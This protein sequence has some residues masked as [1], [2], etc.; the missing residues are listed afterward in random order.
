[1]PRPP[2]GRH[3]LILALVAFGMSACTPSSATG[4][5]GASIPGTVEPSRWSSGN[6]GPAQGE[7]RLMATNFESQGWAYANGRRL[8]ISQ[9]GPLFDLLGVRFGG[10]GQAT[11][12]LP[13]VV[14]VRT[15]NGVALTHQLVL[16]GAKARYEGSGE[17]L[18]EGLV[19]E[20]RLWPGEQVP[21]G[22][23]ACDGQEV[24]VA[25]Y[26][27]LYAVIGTT[28]G[29]DGQTTIKLPQLDAGHGIRYLINVAGT[30]P[31]VEPDAR[32][33]GDPH[34]AQ[35]ALFAGP[36]V[37]VGWRACDGQTYDLRQNLALFSLLG[38]RFGGDGRTTYA[39]P[40]LTF[41]ANPA[42][43]YAIAVQ[44]IFPSRP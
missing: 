14:P 15:A 6:W 37:P 34:L 20:I 11:F 23:L 16:Y 8:P 13:K 21:A 12:D 26:E 29:G 18:G 44:G 24:S 1:M 41:E 38:T 19:G 2:L 39:V 40:K 28:Y 7:F 22:W 27:N 35:I 36:G 3:C 32:P 5:D 33:V 25:Q 10:D 17:G 31:P 4:S 42:I 9:E 30:M 43:H